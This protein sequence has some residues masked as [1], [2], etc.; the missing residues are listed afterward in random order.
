MFEI[1]Q[2]VCQSFFSVFAYVCSNVWVLTFHLFQEYFK[3]AMQ[4]SFFVLVR[5][6][7][8]RLKVLLLPFFF[9]KCLHVDCRKLKS[10]K[11]PSR[12]LCFSKSSFRYSLYFRY[13]V[14]KDAFI[15]I[16]ATALLDLG[17][18]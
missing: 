7:V 13:V 16:N 15:H 2:Y 10:L 1:H 12:S 6:I 8:G 3:Q 17:N 4:K 5:C 9:L 18:F 11:L 14:S